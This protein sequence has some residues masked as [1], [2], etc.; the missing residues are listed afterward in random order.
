ML[1]HMEAKCRGLKGVRYEEPIMKA[2]EDWL[3]RIP[4]LK[5]EVENRKRREE[6]KKAERQ[7]ENMV[8][9]MKAVLESKPQIIQPQG[10]TTQLMKP[11]FPPT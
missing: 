10:Q 9:I 8:H 4:E 3:K 7:G 6:D 1:G 2:F 5:A 11:G